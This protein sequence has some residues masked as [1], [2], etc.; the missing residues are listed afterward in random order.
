MAAAAV[1]QQRQQ[2]L[3]RK[4]DAGAAVLEPSDPGRVVHVHRIGCLLHVLH[5]SVNVGRETVFFMGPLRTG[6]AYYSKDEL[7]LYV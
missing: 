5:L 4:M 7:F 2:Q 3:Q 6:S 1:Q